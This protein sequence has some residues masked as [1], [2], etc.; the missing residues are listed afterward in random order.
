[1]ILTSSS[2]RTF[3]RGATSCLVVGDVTVREEAWPSGGRESSVSVDDGGMVRILENTSTSSSLEPREEGIEIYI[4]P[5]PDGK[6]VGSRRFPWPSQKDSASPPTPSVERA[7]DS[8]TGF[9]PAPSLYNINPS[10][11][12]SAL[13]DDNDDDRYYLPRYHLA[14]IARHF[15][16][17]LLGS[18]LLLVNI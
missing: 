5:H 9:P 15:S 14:H 10:A 17:A 13:D 11:T 6:C 16:S 4:P 12:V 3:C 2:A 7:L 1:M 8:Q 18:F